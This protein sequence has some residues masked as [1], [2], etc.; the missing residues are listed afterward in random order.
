VEELTGKNKIKLILG[1][2]NGIC[3]RIGG[4]QATDDRQVE[5][6]AP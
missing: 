5:V 1:M 2:E 6:S 3:G 4:E